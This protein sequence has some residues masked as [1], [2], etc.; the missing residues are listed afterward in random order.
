MEAAR[1]GEEGRASELS[2]RK[3]NPAE[4]A[5][6]TVD[7]ELEDLK[8]VK[9][10]KLEEKQ[11]ENFNGRPCCSP[12]DDRLPKDLFRKCS[13]PVPIEEDSYLTPE[14]CLSLWKRKHPG[15]PCKE[16]DFD[17]LLDRFDEDDIVLVIRRFPDC[18]NWSKEINNSTDFRDNFC[19][20]P[21]NLKPDNGSAFG[22]EED[23]ESP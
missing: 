2:S 8:V 13:L 15:R 10:A 23:E 17:Y 9:P 4:I 19:E 5:Q 20:I 3:S 14:R 6:H 11:D 1:E 16:Y 7:E 12:Y 18:G 22:D 21:G